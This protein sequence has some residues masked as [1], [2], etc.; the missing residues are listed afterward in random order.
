MEVNSKITILIADD[1]SSIRNGL[2]TAISWDTVPAAVIGQSADGLQALDFIRAYKPDIVITD[3]RM[4]YCDGLELIQRTKEE[5]IDTHFIILS[6]YDDFTYA[7]KAVRLGANSY[8][9]K[10]FKPDELL[11]EVKEIARKIMTKR[12]KD[13]FI[14]NTDLS[15]LQATYKYLF[16]NQ[17]LENEIRE[18]DEI[19]KKVQEFNLHIIDAPLRVMIFSLYNK[20]NEDIHTP[21]ASF[22]TTIS[23]GLPAAHSEV[24]VI[25]K[26]QIAAIINL[27]PEAM[28]LNFHTIAN[29]CLNALKL[30]S[31]RQFSVGIGNEVSG[32]S[33]CSQSY[34]NALIALSYELYE[35]KQ[36]VYDA[37]IINNTAATISPN[38][39][40]TLQLADAICRND[41]TAIVTYCDSFFHSLFYVQMPPPSFVRGMCIYLIADIQKV[42]IKRT[43]SDT[44]T[45][46]ELAYFEIN[47]LTTLSQI[48]SWMIALFL[49]YSDS[50][51]VTVANKNDVI[52]EETKKYIKEHMSEKIKADIIAAHVNLSVTYFT[53]Y[54]KSKTNINFRDYI[55]STKMEY[56]KELLSNPDCSI[57]EVSL[58]IGYEDYRSFYRAFKNHTGL[59]PSEYQHQYD[60]RKKQQ[61][62]R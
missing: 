32:L 13:N 2:N 10:P 48:K 14:Q 19:T 21:I 42:L 23:E 6:G 18:A 30:Q 41:T 57:N 7:Q 38:N 1:E 28:D 59:T 33:T 53:I 34:T 43:H 40:D 17:L 37:S 22:L 24:W 12:K 11:A 61:K 9:L 51:M 54:F 62:K 56:A 29:D 44:E 4:P 46:P 16:M 25:N 5:G 50:V 58:K 39:I 36:S 60:I 35:L 45:F 52:I 27:T 26:N 8:L 3:I 20:T 15:S 49:K 47:Q 31:K 55:L